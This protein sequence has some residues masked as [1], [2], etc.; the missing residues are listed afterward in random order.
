[1]NVLVVEDGYEHSE[2]L[3]KFLPDIQ[4]DRAGSGVDA[5]ARLPGTWDAVFLDMRFDRAPEAELLG[6]LAEVADRFNGDPVLAR[7]HLEDHQGTYVLHAIR[8]AGHRVPILMSYD[9][10]GEPRRWDRL[11]AR[12]GA[13]DYLP[14]NAGPA[15]VA[16]RL[17]RLTRSGG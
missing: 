17:A 5:L 13:V 14:G 15:E 11:A 16:A 9:F 2:A 12:Y 7:R 10:D 4:W 6:D 1:M 3:R 8:A